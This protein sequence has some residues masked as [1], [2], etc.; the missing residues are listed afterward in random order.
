MIFLADRKFDK[1]RGP[2]NAGPIV[3]DGMRVFEVPDYLGSF[4]PTTDTV[5]S[6]EVLKFQ[7]IKDHFPSLVNVVNDE[8]EGAVAPAPGTISVGYSYGAM[9][10][11]SLAPGGSVVLGPWTMMSAP[12]SMAFRIFPYKLVYDTSGKTPRYVAT[13]GSFSMSVDYE[14]TITDSTGT[15]NH[16]TV[17]VLDQEISPS[18]STLPSFPFSFGVKLVNMSTETMFFSDYYV[19]WGP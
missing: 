2:F 4:M 11:A 8:F 3:T 12:S 13:F 14:M 9:K 19:M 15:T 6:L 10:I 17:G 5:A 18:W 7:K 1:I 16:L